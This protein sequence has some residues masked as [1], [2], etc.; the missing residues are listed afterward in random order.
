M[1]G[2]PLVVAYHHF[3]KFLSIII[4]K[5]FSLLHIDEDGKKVFTPQP[6]VSCH[7]AHKLRSK[8][9]RAKLYQVEVFI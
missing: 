5:N 6:M 8:L 1:K 7:S 3:L 2:I 9:V 4:N